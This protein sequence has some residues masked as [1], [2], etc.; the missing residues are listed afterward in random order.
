MK[1]LNLKNPF[2][3]P[4]YH[5]ETVSSTS[6]VSRNLA[7][8]GKPHG[9]VITADFQEAGRGRSKRPWIAQKGENL[10][11]TV[12]LRYGES[13][14]IPKA[15]T[16][17]TGLAVSFAIEDL[18]PSLAAQV[19]VKWPNDI[20]INSLKVAGILTEWDGK[21]AYIGVGVNVSQ[22]DFPGEYKTKAGSIIQAY[23]DLGDNA[24]F[25]LLE[26]I[27]SRLYDEIETP[28][29][30]ASPESGARRDRWRERLEKRLYKRGE[31]VSFIPGAAD[32]GSVVQ[33]TL[34][35]IGPEGEL[36]IIPEGEEKERAFASGELRVYKL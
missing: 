19:T 8:E 14:S 2:G 11:F 15:L 18:V 24:R 35:G 13:S 27:L 21:T 29:F 17:R 31:T 5:E 9:T 20:I 32:S 6:D 1:L 22:R 7:A 10:L 4:V 16:L 34:S 36:L 28:R 25:S 26:K 33:G 12:M 3:A 30:D 23:P